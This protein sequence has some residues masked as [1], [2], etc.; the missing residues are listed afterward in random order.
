MA[1]PTVL[2][3]ELAEF[4]NGAAFKPS[5][6]EG[7]GTPIVRIQNLT[8]PSSDINLTN[9]TVD[10]KYWIENG[11]LL[12]AWSAS[13]G[14]HFW[15]GN[16]AYLNQH[17]FKVTPKQGVLKDYVYFLLQNITEHLKTQTHGS[18][19]KHVTKKVFERTPVPLPPLIEQQRIVDILNHASS[20]RRLREQ[21]QTKI[22]KIIPALFVEMFGDPASNPKGWD[23][24]KVGDCINSADYG[25]SKKA[26]EEEV[27]LP[28]LRMGNVTYDGV[29]DLSSLKYVELDDVEIEKYRLLEGDILFNRTNS[30]ELVGKTG[31][32]DGRYDAIA[33][34]YFIRLRANT[35]KIHPKYLWAFFNMAY[36][37]KKLFETARG[38]IG[39]ANINA[40]EVKDFEIG[41]PPLE[42]QIEFDRRLK[43]LS[44]ISSVSAAADTVAEHLSNAL[45]SKA[46]S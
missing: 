11:E 6:W 28:V 43:E 42:L 44:S 36:M 8:N 45:L 39:Q 35:D 21:A 1:F 17:I 31:I 13:L 24:V 26:A 29:L 38:A 5:D 15:H 2:L 40:K 41:L 3:G 34:S 33:A 46:F 20:I 27:G 23:V 9:K 32:W 16:R 22:K 30:K 37:K 14:A 4:Q 19:M 12:F 25:S 18:T 7:T 10:Q